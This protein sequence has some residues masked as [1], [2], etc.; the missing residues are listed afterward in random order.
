MRRIALFLLPI[1]FVG[2]GTSPQ[3]NNTAAEQILACLPFPDAPNAGVFKSAGSIIPSQ[4][5]A[6]IL[7]PGNSGHF[8]SVATNCD[9]ITT[10][11]VGPG[12]A[13]QDYG[14]N[15]DDQRIN[16]R[17]E[18]PVHMY[19]DS[20]FKDGRFFD[21][22]GQ[23]PVDVLRDGDVVIYRDDYGVPIIIA[24]DNANNDPES[25]PS[26]DIWYG[27]GYAAAQDRLF[28]LDAA[29]RQAQ[30]TLAEVLGAGTVPADVQARV[31]TYTDAEY[32]AQIALLSA[33][34]QQALNQYREG[35]NAWIARVNDQGD[36]EAEL[37][38]EFQV[39]GYTPT[40]I[41]N[42]DIAALGVLMTRF[43]AASGGD[44]MENVK[45]LQALE[46]QHGK[47]VGRQLFKDTNW[48]DDKKAT[49]TIPGIEFTNISTP[50]VLRDAVFEAMADWATSLPAELADGPGTG[51]YPEP[52]IAQ[53]K[54][55][56]GY[57]WDV[58]PVLLA[59]T[60]K[61]HLP[62]PTKTS[63]SY[64]SVVSPDITGDGSTLL[65]NGP[66]LGY[67]YP[68]L[69]YEFEIHGGGYNSRGVSVP[70]LP[71]QG[72]GYGARL[73]WGL[74]TG[75]SKTIDSFIEEI[76][77]PVANTYRHDGEVKTMEC[78]TELVNYRSSDPASGAPVPGSAPDSGGTESIE[79]CRTVHGPV[80]AESDDGTL[81]RSLQYA[82]WMRELET[83]EGVLDWSKATNAA[84]FE[85]AMRKVTW[86]ENTMY[87]DADGNIAYY[88]PGLHHWRHP[89]ADQRWPTKG[90]GSQ[91]ICGELPFENRPHIR[92]PARGYLTNWNNKP[93]RGWGENSGGDASQ[94][95]AGE[96][97][98]NKNWEDLLANTPGITYE[99]LISLDRAIGRVDPKAGALL[100]PILA[101]DQRCGLSANE[102]TLIDILKTWDKQHYSE[103]ID[104]DAAADEAGATDDPAPTIFSAIVDAM[105]SDMTNG[106]LPEAYI[107]RHN[108][109]GNHPYDAGTFH[110][111]AAKLLDPSKSTITADY[112]WLRGRSSDE[113]VADSITSAL[114]ALVTVYGSNPQNFRRMHARSS[115]T[116]LA[117]PLAGPD[118]TMPHQD[119]GSWIHMVGYPPK[120]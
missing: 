31:T 38:F 52:S 6:S 77:D 42:A 12:L 97:G 102:Q 30:G 43:V 7:P 88:H 14:P 9:P 27:A 92:N 78:R 114:D 82:M 45:A 66:Q 106:V 68:T 116:A 89:S 3:D 16:R 91:D 95:P 1:G 109:R 57:K 85:A 120:P 108:R 46:A 39:L 4:Q 79:V 32:N 29:V 33:D 115:V 100:Q 47:E 80:V 110:K 73:A 103:G 69:L 23:I 22:T 61:R 117:A 21:T 62:R 41:T 8:H 83:T 54:L 87:T 72:I 67:T 50:L 48:L 63:A 56:K 93:A 70:G 96:N 64:M 65:I 107:T 34:V 86:N 11:C 74:T 99:T 55:P 98:R 59:K 49:V 37:P 84:E 90:D 105:I 28:L 36:T 111:L 5:I 75:E 18:N 113:F 25:G 119:R 60:I 20:K 2:C 40:P 112:A 15:I 13:P 19:W 35:A 118:I 51:A 94:L 76:V 17:G 10:P 24:N 26:G 71:V 104:L 44:E 53:M 58:D 101:C 81:A